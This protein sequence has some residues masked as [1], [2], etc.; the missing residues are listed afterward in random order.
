MCLLSRSRVS[1]QLGGP[2]PAG[3]RKWC[4]IK[5]T[6]WL[7]LGKNDPNCVRVRKKCPRQRNNSK[8]NGKML[9]RRVCPSPGRRPSASPYP[10]MMMVSR[11]RGGRGLKS[12]RESFRRDSCQKGRIRWFFLGKI[13]FLQDDRGG[14]GVFGSRLG[15]ARPWSWNAGLVPAH[16][17]MT[18]HRVNV[19][20]Y[21]GGLG[22]DQPANGGGM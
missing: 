7:Y 1:W 13:S 3:A 11:G 22:K 18:R 5:K 17:P 9:G 16:R 21:R 8:Y 4:W 20:G 19:C 14:Q 6:Q 12:W 15:T 10:R 2:A